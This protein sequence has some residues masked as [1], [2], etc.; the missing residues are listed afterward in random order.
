MH[1]HRRDSGALDGTPGTSARISLDAS[2]ESSP[3]GQGR[4]R[5]SGESDRGHTLRQ[6]VMLLFMSPDICI[7]FTMATLFGF[8]AGVIDGF[9][10]LYLEELGGPK[11]L[12]GLTITVGEALLLAEELSWW[13][14]SCRSGAIAVV[15]ENRALGASVGVALR[16]QT[17]LL[18]M[19]SECTT[20]FALVTE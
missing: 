17:E 16:C 2:Q 20:L 3:A 9:L 7:F 14:K 18:Q 15:A 19:Q 12:C 10:F 13:Q 1:L 5:G 4:R 11:V 6:K 8:A